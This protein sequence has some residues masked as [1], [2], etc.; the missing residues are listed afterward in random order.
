MDTR[1]TTPQEGKVTAQGFQQFSDRYHPTVEA[2]AAEVSAAK[3]SAKLGYEVIG[4]LCY[5]FARWLTVQAKEAGIK[6]LFF[7]SRDGWLLKQAFDLL[8]SEVTAGI[9]SHYLYSSRRAV[10]F[11]SLK[12]DTP[13]DEF[14]EILSG[15]SPYLPVKAYLLRLFMEPSDYMDEIKN[16]GFQD[17]NC[18]VINASDRRKLYLLLDS[19]RPTI[20]AMAAKERADYLAYL[21]LSGVL[22][23]PKPGLVDVGWTGSVL[24]YTRSLVKDS[25]SSADLY[26]YFIG[27]GA[28]AH[29]KYGFNKGECLHGY[30]FDFDDESHAEIRKY[31]F[32]IEKFLSPNAPSLMKM[33]RTDDGLGFKPIYAQGQTEAVPRSSTVQKQALK[34]VADRAAAGAEGVADQSLFLPQLKKVLTNPEPG[35]ARLLSQ[36]SYSFD[37][38]YYRAPATYAKTQSPGFYLRHPVQLL[39]DYRRALWKPGYV[40]LQPTPARAA[41][42]LVNRTGLDRLFEQ[43]VLARKK[44]F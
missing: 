25:G 31:F 6:N 19:L 9:T 11:A 12:E 20:V 41:L 13:D 16:A 34:F 44:M 5:S 43:A 21:Q 3:L 8:P 23:D 38:G 32:I 26:G 29:K 30:L 37:F 1:N 4:P 28:N 18:E 10:W 39:K 42:K 7:L 17:E 33:G 36:Y 14:Y 27:V 40:A 35:V 2:D 22:D 15:A 24:K